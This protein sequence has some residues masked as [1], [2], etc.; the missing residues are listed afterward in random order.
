MRYA[1]FSIDR[2]S[3]SCCDTRDSRQRHGHVVSRL[4][5]LEL[6]SDSLSH[7]HIMSDVARVGVYHACHVLPL[8][9]F[10]IMAQARL[11]RRHAG[12]A[13]RSDTLLTQHGE[14]HSAQ[15]LGLHPSRRAA[16]AAA[17]AAP[18]TPRLMSAARVDPVV[19]G[20][21]LTFRGDG[22]G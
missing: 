17:R 4:S 10:V 1:M 16:A 21:L 18:S 14:E 3:P 8:G 12:R 13:V 15:R 9:G 7:Q 2:R 6:L 19:Y 20:L 22:Y 11:A 5:S